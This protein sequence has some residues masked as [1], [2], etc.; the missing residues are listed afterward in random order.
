MPGGDEDDIEEYPDADD[1]KI[2]LNVNDISAVEVPTGDKFQELY[3]DAQH[4]NMRHNHIYSKCI[5]KEC[6]FKP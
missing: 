5:D 2:N 6:T 1:P 3:V 4:R